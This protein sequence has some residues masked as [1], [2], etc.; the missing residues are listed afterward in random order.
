MR[1]D[2]TSLNEMIRAL[3]DGRTFYQ[4]AASKVT[5]EDLKRLF[6]RMA[7]TKTAIVNDMKNKVVFSGEEP[8]DD[9]SLGGGVRKA[10]AD[11]RAK[12]ATDKEASYVAQLEQFEDRIL[13]SFRAAITESKDPEVRG[14]AQKYMPDVTRDHDEMRAL[15]LALKH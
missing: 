4:D 11:I 9:G 3:N 13:E 5:R 14:L 1:N 2:A 12:L 10:Y 7:R 6:E 15:K 8:S